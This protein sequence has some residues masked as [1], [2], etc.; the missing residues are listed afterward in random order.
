MDAPRRTRD[1]ADL[2]GTHWAPAESERRNGA[3][4]RAGRRTIR[5]IGN[6]DVLLAGEQAASAARLTVLVH[7]LGHGQRRPVPHA[8]CGCVGTGGPSNLLRWVGLARRWR[9]RQLHG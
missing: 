7:I 4:G 6:E 9:L 8:I 5:R 2:A 3:L 1:G